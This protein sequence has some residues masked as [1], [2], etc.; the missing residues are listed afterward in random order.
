MT[1]IALITACLQATPAL[2]VLGEN[3]TTAPSKEQ[4]PLAWAKKP[5]KEW[6]QFVLTNEASF[7]G[8]TSLKGASAFLMLMSDNDVLLVTARHLIGAEGGVE[9]P[10][11]LGDFDKSLSKWEAFPRT[12]PDARVVVTGLAMADREG[13]RHD[14]LLLFL[15]DPKGKLPATPLR[16]RVKKAN[17]GD[18]AYLIGVPYSDP[19]SAQNVYKGKVTGR[20][21]KNYF[22]MEFE[23]AVK[24]AGFSGA[25]VVDEH[26]YLLGMMT[27]SP[28]S[29]RADGLQT[30]CWCQDISM[31]YSLWRKKEKTPTTKPS[32]PVDLVLPA[33][34]KEEP[35]TVKNVVKCA[36]YLELDASIQLQVF[37]A[38]KSNG[39][40][41]LKEWAVRN[42]DVKL[43]A[44]LD[45]RRETELTSIKIG[46][47]EAYDYEVSGKSNGMEIRYR[48][49]TF[50]RNKCFCN[51]LCWTFGENWSKAQPKFEEILKAIK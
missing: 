18:V 21:G 3:T 41:T 28:E 47:I 15:K 4:K 40:M 19:K 38:E 24:L 26:G 25:P 1:S 20:P 46:S 39:V 8:H 29:K 44:N 30:A 12:R 49:I 5:V 22:A 43:A 27:T 23:P 35:S 2:T 16:P 50:E 33:G 9:P 37:P 17:I 6:P 48:M 11:A 34:W 14:W 31:G 7:K 45:D 42:K 13:A 32:A 36:E 51:L 10:V